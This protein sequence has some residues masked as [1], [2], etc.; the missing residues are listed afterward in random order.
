MA[1]RNPQTHKLRRLAVAVAIYII[2]VIGLIAFL[3][4]S[5]YY[6]REK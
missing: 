6:G 1:D 2:A 3:I 5:A 4:G